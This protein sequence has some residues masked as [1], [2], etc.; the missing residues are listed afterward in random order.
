MKIPLKSTPLKF[1]RHPLSWAFKAGNKRTQSLARFVCR[2]A[3]KPFQFR[4]GRSRGKGAIKGARD[5]LAYGERIDSMDADLK[6]KRN[7]PQAGGDDK[8]VS[9][10][11]VSQETTAVQRP[12]QDLDVGTVLACV[13]GQSWRELAGITSPLAIV[14]LN[15]TMQTVGLLNTIESKTK[16]TVKGWLRGASNSLSALA[17]SSEVV[18][19]K[20]TAL[21]EVYYTDVDL[22]A[23][24]PSTSR[25]PYDDELQ[26]IQ[27]EMEQL[28]IIK[29]K[30]TMEVEALF[31]NQ[32]KVAEAQQ[33]IGEVHK[34]TSQLYKANQESLW[35]TQM[36]EEARRRELEAELEAGEYRSAM[37]NLFT[38]KDSLES[39]LEA[40]ERQLSSASNSL[41]ES[42]GTIG[43]LQQELFEAR[44]RA[45]EAEE[46]A[47]RMERQSR[48]K[49]WPTPKAPSKQ[50]HQFEKEKGLFLGEK[51]SLN[52]SAKGL[53]APELPEDF[54][55]FI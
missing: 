12:S 42:S 21:R 28:K 32:K 9:Q 14:G 44:R 27:N 52:A 1:C 49:S 54:N 4:N 31:E 35:L 3:T 6:S 19:E 48:T 23:V 40:R 22:L 47:K 37:E 16:S 10:A 30:A 17:G 51:E 50:A 38:V 41:M 18:E 13:S 26:L 39:A 24:D 5:A 43:E 53:E 11:F 33:H 34:V 25:S 55:Y 29:D 8:L 45:A 20:D 7:L 36:L 15:F 46:R 2:S